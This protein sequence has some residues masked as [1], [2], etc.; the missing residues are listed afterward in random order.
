VNAPTP[1]PFEAEVIS[2]KKRDL[3]ELEAYE[4]RRRD[5]A[6]KAAE[7]KATLPE[8]AAEAA[9][10]LARY[11]MTLIEAAHIVAAILDGRQR[12]DTEVVE[13]EDTDLAAMGTEE[14][15]ED[16]PE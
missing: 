1:R 10:I 5:A 14:G 13:I 12:G 16:L 11:G 15:A 2:G 4:K 7:A 6:V 9:K 3:A 8:H